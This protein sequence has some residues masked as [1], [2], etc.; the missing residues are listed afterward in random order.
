MRKRPLRLLSALALSGGL[1]L[2]G[3]SLASA[4]SAVNINVTLPAVTKTTYSI[5]GIVYN[6]AGTAG[7]QSV[8]VVADS[9]GFWGT[10]YSGRANTTASGA[11]SIAGHQ[12]GRRDGD[13]R[14]GG[15]RVRN[16]GL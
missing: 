12:D 1:L 10:G 4:A 5:S 6:A 11:Y 13:R 3:T 14:A 7:V 15:Q 9:T 2:S 8:E 16:P